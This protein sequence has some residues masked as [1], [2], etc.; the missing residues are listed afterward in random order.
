MRP[1]PTW[2][3]NATG[4]RRLKPK[5]KRGL[6]FLIFA[7]IA[8]PV[9]R[10]L[11]LAQPPAQSVETSKVTLAQAAKAPVPAPLS[12]GQKVVVVTMANWVSCKSFDDTRRLSGLI[13]S[14]DM[15]RY[16]TSLQ[17]RSP[18]VNVAICQRAQPQSSKI[19][20]GTDITAFVPRA[21][22]TVCGLTGQCSKMLQQRRPKIKN[23]PHSV[24]S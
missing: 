1:N 17:S 22:L 23:G 18:Q 15:A 19:P 20:I 21:I 4:K 10:A 9:I 2:H 5:T 14:D 12:I 7:L 8:L 6:A 13:R 3:D 16:R 11:T 24:P